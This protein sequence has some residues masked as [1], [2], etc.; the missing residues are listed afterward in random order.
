MR[1]MPTHTDV[2]IGRIA[3]DRAYLT[4]EQLLRCLQEQVVSPATPLGTIML[5]HGFIKTHDLESL[6]EEQKRRLAEALELSD[7]KLEDA[8]LGRLLIKQ[9][10][11]REAQVYECLRVQAEIGER[12]HKSP[13]LGTL[14]V[15]RGFLSTDAI[16][17]ALLLTRKDRLICRANSKKPGTE[18]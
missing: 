12:G 2:L 16:D 7:P 3:L 13:R 1:T 6:L 8:L 18:D 11:A 5:R 14:L 4:E 17:T 10:L 15:R 9:G